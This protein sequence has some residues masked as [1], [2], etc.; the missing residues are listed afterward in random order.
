METQVA[1]QWV[2]IDV[3][4][5][6]L[7]IALRPVNK[8][9]Q[10]T[11]QE[12]GWLEL[13]EQLKKYKIE[14]II[15]E[16]TG[17]ME[18]GVAHKLQKEEFKVAVINPKRARDFAEVLAHFG[19][20]LQP[21]PKP[22]ASESQVALSDLVNRRSQLVEMLNSEQKRAHSVRSSTA[23]ADIET[24]I[25]WLKQRIK[26]MDEQIDQ[27]RQDNE[28]SK[29]QYELL[30]SVPGVGR[31]TAVTL[32]SML[33]ELGELP[34]K[35]LSSLVGIA[36]MNCDSGQMRGKRR[37]IGGRA[38]VRAVLYMS[39]LVAIQHNPVIKAFYQKLLQAGKAKKV[40]LI[41]CAH[42]LLGFLHAIVKSQKPWRCPENIETKEEKLQAC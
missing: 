32:L 25:Q 38:R 8:V 22:L 37:I 7:N 36:P 9:L 12:S 29:K 20:A 14:L 16:S 30:T 6:K 40:A 17:G 2:G 42:K 3:S 10:V 15:I 18:R 39:A 19:E 4:K 24:N 26:G 5:A 28:E 27:L 33:P 11:N 21:S 13:S 35:K 31:V 1:G 23:K 34:L 41:A